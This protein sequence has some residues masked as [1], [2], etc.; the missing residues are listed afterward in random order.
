VHVDY[1]RKQASVTVQGKQTDSST[2]L[3]ALHAEGYGG[4]VLAER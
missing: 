3:A 4:S 2:L 1:G